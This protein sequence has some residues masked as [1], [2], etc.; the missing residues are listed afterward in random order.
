MRSI[1]HYA[2]KFLAAFFK[3]LARGPNSLQLWNFSIKRRRIIDNLVSR[4]FHSCLDVFSE[5]YLSKGLDEIIVFPS[6]SGLRSGAIA[7]RPAARGAWAPFAIVVS[8]LL[9]AARR[10]GGCEGL[11]LCR[12]VWPACPT[13]GHFR[14]HEASRALR[15]R[16]SSFF[17]CNCLM[18]NNPRR[19]CTLGSLPE[20]LYLLYSLHLRAARMQHV[21]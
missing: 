12:L 4:P 21:H 19:Q 1:P 13:G 9:P 3:G 2:L 17:G 20:H 7:A 11:Q 10:D 18:R 8:V 14:G 16:T 6:L 5:H 15:F